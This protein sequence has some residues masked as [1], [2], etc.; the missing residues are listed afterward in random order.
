MVTDFSDV[1]FQSDPF[2]YQPKQWQPPAA[3]L[4][5][6]LEAYPNKV[7]PTRPRR[8]F[9]PPPAVMLFYLCGGVQVINRCPFNGGWIRSCYGEEG[10]QR[11][12]THT[13]SCSGVTLGTRD[14][15]L[16]YTYLVGQQMDPK[17][18]DTPHTR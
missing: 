16:V 12:G 6:F 7:R 13:V 1:V 2:T 15:M 3:Q 18:T 10:L 8:P 14:A 17:V 4:A 5:V 11:I 9:F